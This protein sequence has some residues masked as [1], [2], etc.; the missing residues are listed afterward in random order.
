MKILTQEEHN[1]KLSPPECRNFSRFDP[2]RTFISSINNFVHLND[3]QKAVPAL[4]NSFMHFNH[5][6]MNPLPVTN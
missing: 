5:P 6:Y 4:L 3:P 1:S 2:F